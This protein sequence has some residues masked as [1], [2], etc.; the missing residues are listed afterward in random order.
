MILYAK[1]LACF[2]ESSI[3]SNSMVQ[4]SS[5]CEEDEVEAVQSKSKEDVKA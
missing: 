1:W 4:H 3:C 2:R 5:A